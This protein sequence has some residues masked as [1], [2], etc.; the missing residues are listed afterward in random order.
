MTGGEEVVLKVK[1]DSG[2]YP[3]HYLHDGLV[4]L[5]RKGVTFSPTIG[6]DGFKVSPDKILE[7]INQP[8]EASRVLLRVT[9]KNA[10]RSF[11]RDIEGKKEFYF[12][13]LGAVTVGVGPGGTGL[14]I[15]CNGCDDSMNVLSALL[16]K[17]RGGS[18]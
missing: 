15:A 1:Y 11:G 6:G 13:N 4:K 14:S 18:K 16:E 8:Q 3:Y 2:V 7:V 17:V 10:R 9:V 12:Y 5:S